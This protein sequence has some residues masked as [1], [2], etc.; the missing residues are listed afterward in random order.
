MVSER[1][2]TIEML[3]QFICCNG[4]PCLFKSSPCLSAS[5]LYG[6]NATDA[7]KGLEGT[8]YVIVK[9]E[10]ICAG[11]RAKVDAEIERLKSENIRLREALGEILHAVCSA[12]RAALEEEEK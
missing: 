9:R 6:K 4:G 3:A 2:K 1:E 11:E 10:A 12:A 8:D 7:V 5:L